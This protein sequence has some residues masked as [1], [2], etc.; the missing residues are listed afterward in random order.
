MAGF[1]VFW[2]EILVIVFPIF[3]YQ[4]L[5]DQDLCQ[6]DRE[7]PGTLTTVGGIGVE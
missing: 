2:G 7:T 1:R 6:G 4:E 5:V 3:D